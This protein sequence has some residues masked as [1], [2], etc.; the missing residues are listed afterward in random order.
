VGGDHGDET[1]QREDILLGG[2]AGSREFLEHFRG[3]GCQAGKMEGVWGSPA[4][5]GTMTT[6]RPLFRSAK[7]VV[8]VALDRRVSRW[9]GRG[10]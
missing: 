8:E 5:V 9:S 3:A 1:E 6:L 10:E 7:Q 2:G 4:A